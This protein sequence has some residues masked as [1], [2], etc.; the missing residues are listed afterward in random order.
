MD[1][2]RLRR[3]RGFAIRRATASLRRLP[4]FLVVGAMKSGTSTLFHH[5]V[6][7]PDILGPLRKEVHYFGRAER[8]GHGLGWY[9][10]H[11]PARLPWRNGTLTG[12]ATPGYLFDPEAPFA[13]AR[14]LPEVR[15]L[16]ILREPAAR[17]VSHYHHEVRMGRETLPVA[18]ALAVED[19]RLDHAAALG[20]AGRETLEH[21]SYRRRGIYADQIA[22]YHAAFGPDR[23]LV[24]GTGELARDPAAALGRAFAFLGLPPAPLGRQRVRNR[25][26]GAAD[27]PPGVLSELRG[28]Y[29]PHN[30]RLE[31]LL[32][33]LPDWG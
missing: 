13:I 12:E 2:R 23:L 31:A 29:A 11:F 26:K 1:D 5:L 3:G 19:E 8:L 15:L 18:D 16:A 20:E 28:W 14:L 9:R 7:H 30:A 27:V 22:R 21:A 10:S 25:G 33:G 4:D 17:A 32:G 24:L 6:Q